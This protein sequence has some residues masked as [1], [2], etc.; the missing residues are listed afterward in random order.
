[1]NTINSADWQHLQQDW[2]S[3]PRPDIAVIKVSGERVR[4]YLQGQLTQDIKKL[5]ASAGIYACVLSPQGKAVSDIRILAVNEETLLLLAPAAY[6]ESLL[7][8]LKRFSLGFQLTFEADANHAVLSIQG[9]NCDQALSQAGLPVPAASEAMASSR[10][11]AADTITL[12]M[13]EASGHG[14]WV[15]LPAT[16]LAPTLEALAHSVEPEVLDA[17]CTLHGSPRFGRDWDESNYPLNANLIEYDGVSFDKGCYVGQ[18]I[19]SRMRWRGGIKKKLYRVQL[20]SLPDTLPCPVC[21]TVNIG[22]LTAASTTPEGQCFGIAVLPIEV[23]EKASPLSIE[24]VG[25]IQL[26]EACHA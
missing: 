19:T 14:A 24:G 13:P 3:A 8:R 11:D 23:V 5:T 26:L 6:M 2:L 1:M 16:K 9:P 21:T 20:P 15:I 7:A 22:S 18:E 25:P 10:N 17:A 4:D 12:R